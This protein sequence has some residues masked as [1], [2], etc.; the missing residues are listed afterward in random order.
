MKPMAEMEI[1]AKIG[2]LPNHKD[3]TKYNAREDGV[4]VLQSLDVRRRRCGLKL[5]SWP[6]KLIL[7][8]GHHNLVAWTSLKLS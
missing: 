2:K 1:A 6:Q 7:S 3:K 4:E 5:T 8:A